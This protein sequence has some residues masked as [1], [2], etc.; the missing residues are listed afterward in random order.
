MTR[1]LL[2]VLLA[3]FALPV[4]GQEGRKRRAD[5]A[6]DKYAYISSE[7]LYKSLVEQGFESAELYGKLADTYYFNSRYKEAQ[8]YYEKMFSYN[9]EVAPEYYYRY[10]QCLRV[11]GDTEKATEYLEH[12]YTQ[13]GTDK[14]AISTWTGEV[15]TLPD[16]VV[17]YRL[18]DAGINSDYADFSTAY[19]RADQVLISSARDTG[20]LIN[21]RHKWNAMPFLKFYTADINEDGT[22]SNPKQLKGKVNSKYHQTTAAVTRDGKI[23]YFTRNNYRS[24]KFGKD[25]EGTNH[26][27]I[28]RTVFDG[29]K[30]GEV[31]D[32]SIND[33]TYS[34]A[35]P[36]LSPEEDYLYFVSDRDGSLGD[37]DIFKVKIA[38]DGSF[39]DVEN[40]GLPVN[41]AGKES[42][43][44][45]DENGQLYFASNG[46]PGF[47]GL[48]VFALQ[49]GPFGEARV[50]NLGEPVNTKWDDFGFVMRGDGKGFLSSNRNEESGFDN[51]YSVVGA[52]LDLE[53]SLCGRVIDSISRAPLVGAQV[54]IR[55]AENQ[56]LAT[57][58]SDADGRFCVPVWPFEGYAL[59][60]EKT[61]YQTKEQWIAPLKNK[62]KRELLVEL[63]NSKMP[64]APGDD[65]TERLGLKPIYFDFDGSGIRKVS[66]IELGKVIAVLQKYP[67]LKVDVRSHTDSRGSHAYNEALS[68]RRA[69]ATIDYIVNKG[70]IDPERVSGRGYGE[71]QLIN[72]CADGV[73]CSREA[74]QLNRR[75][76]FIV[77]YPVN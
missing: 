33:K 68:E 77:T 76:E 29:E 70:G 39:G 64:F 37:T 41:T 50:L 28:Y 72:E 7:E 18:Q 60:T 32:L 49:E 8:Q 53:A 48:D 4:H 44:F 65:L 43:P 66:E 69:K 9:T 20:T 26:L 21:R 31:E 36:A 47:G 14:D 51:I 12:F 73:D 40:L 75:S 57:V 6:Y 24:G 62:E 59:R 30:W 52:P 3:V 5:K 11:A 15:T 71:T 22:L 35:H 34:T 19:Y 25:D 63:V 61:D 74:H 1:Y 67:D 55:N 13:L 16:G 56:V 23:M 10:G 42:F 54:G 17:E 45:I 2:I 58:T 46:H 27:K 38:E